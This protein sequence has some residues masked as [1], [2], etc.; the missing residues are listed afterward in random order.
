MSD[1]IFTVEGDSIIA[2]APG[3]EQ[4]VEGGW[5]ELFSKWIGEHGGVIRRPE[6]TTVLNWMTKE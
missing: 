4:I 6:Q 3:D 5:S 1:K 2:L